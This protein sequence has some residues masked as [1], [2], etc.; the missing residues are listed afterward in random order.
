MEAQRAAAAQQTPAQQS[1]AVPVTPQ[2][3]NAPGATAQP[4]T[5]AAKSTP[6]KTQ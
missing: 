3:L 1:S 2:Q 5:G 6:K 4:A